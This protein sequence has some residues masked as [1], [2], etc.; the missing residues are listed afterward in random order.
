MGLVLTMA[1]TGWAAAQ[2]LPPLARTLEFRLGDTAS[3][4]GELLSAERDSLWILPPDGGVRVVGL[5][6]VSQVRRRLS[7]MSAG[8]ILIWA[9][10][11]GLA[12]GGGLTAACANVEDTSCGA[13]L[14]VTLGLW[15][16]A[17]GVAAAVSG[18]GQRTVALTVNALRPYARFPQGLP[19]G[20]P[21]AGL[22]REAREVRSPPVERRDDL[23]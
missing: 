2:E 12:S 22:R 23:E 8:G 6:D 17:G 11:G 13:V 19:D 15:W 3:L 1:A 4:R 18:S 7:G 10:L 14:P 5:R 9:T 21:L 16:L 20:F